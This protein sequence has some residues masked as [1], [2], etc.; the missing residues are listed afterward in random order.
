MQGV[1]RGAAMS[2]E[3]DPRTPAT[4]LARLRQDPQ[5]E[6]AWDE[7][8]KRYRPKIH[9][10]CRAWGLQPADAD[11]VT[12]NVLTK[13]ANKMRHFQ[14]DPARSFRAWLRTVTHHAWSDFTADLRPGV[15][16]GELAGLQTL[17][18]RADLAQRLNEEFD[19]ELLE[20]AVES[21]KGR[22]AAQT[23]EAFRLT[24]L[25]G[26]SGAE[27]AGRLGQQVGTVF[28]AK[29]RVQKM[30]QEEIRRLETAG[31]EE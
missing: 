22:V 12:Q 31:Q 2:N 14:Y 27:A 9:G 4:L 7:F 17:E 15:G 23:W 8:D 5:D 6:Q 24:T 16:G 21:V 29:H 13:L 28:V 19:H 18:A 1:I 20:A 11:D 30:L 26:L 10:W 25:E 3:R